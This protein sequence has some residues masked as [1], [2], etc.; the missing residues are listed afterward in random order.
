MK[1]TDSLVMEKIKSIH[2][3]IKWD[4]AKVSYIDMKTLK[5]LDEEQFPWIKTIK[6]LIYDR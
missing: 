4:D 1:K 3:V 2:I 6:A 5:E